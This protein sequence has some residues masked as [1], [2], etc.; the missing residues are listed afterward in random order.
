MKVER[1]G[2][3]KEWTWAQYYADAMIAGRALV[4]LG[5]EPSDTVNIIGFNSRAFASLDPTT[6][7]SY[8]APKIP[9]W[10]LPP[11]QVAGSKFRAAEWFIA[12]MA[13]ILLAAKPRGSTTNAPEACKYVAE[14]R[15]LK[16][17]SW[18]MRSSY[19]NS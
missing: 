3:W 12:E 5:L 17:C 7:L 4:T 14:H 10:S 9:L 13:A 15:R 6:S 18:R 16:S 1:D 11:N 19:A 8:P 2:V